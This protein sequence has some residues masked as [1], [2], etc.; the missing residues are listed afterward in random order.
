MA[1]FCEMPS[2]AKNDKKMIF[3]E[4]Y[5]YVFPEDIVADKVLLVYRLYQVIET[6]KKE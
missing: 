2:E 1:Y 3:G 4:K 6:H 5:E